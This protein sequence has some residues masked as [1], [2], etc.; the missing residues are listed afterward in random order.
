M[1]NFEFRPETTWKIS[2]PEHCVKYIEAFRRHYWDHQGVCSLIHDF[3]S[4]KCNVRTICELGSGTGVNLMYLSDFGYECFGYD[5]NQESISISRKRSEAIGKNI[6]F[7]LLDFTKSLP[8]RQFDVVISLFVPVSLVDMT[9]LLERSSQI[10]APGGYFVCML[11]SV[12]PEFEEINHHQETNTE[13]LRIENTPV[14]RFNFYNK[15]GHQIEY[16]GVY[17]AGEAQGTQMFCDWDRYDLLTKAQVLDLS[18]SCFRQVYRTPIQGKPY[19]CPPMTYEILDI[20]Q[21][22]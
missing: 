7:E 8:E 16:N 2:Y 21:K 14:I 3:F 19:Q 1:S 15:E 20:F 10:V 6:N 22:I 11:L 13:F 5:S 4:S 9:R 18:N 17:F 12:L